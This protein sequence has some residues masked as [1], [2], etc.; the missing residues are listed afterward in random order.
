MKSDYLEKLYNFLSE[1]HLNIR[2]EVLIAELKE[3]SE[4][5]DDA[6]LIAN[7]STF[8]RTSAGDVL[9]VKLN[10]SA[11]K[12]MMELSRNGLYDNLPEGLFHTQTISKDTQSYIE[13]RKVIKSEEQSSRL[14]FSPIENE[15]F[16]QRLEI[17]QNERKLLNSFSK[18]QNEFLFD[19]WKID[20]EIPGDYAVKLMALLP[21][22]DRIVGDLA[23]TSLCLEKILNQKV[24]MDRTTKRM[25]NE[26]GRDEV[27]ISLGHDTVLEPFNYSVEM[28]ALNIMI[29][30]IP[31]ENIDWYLNEMKLHEFLEVFY[32]YFVPMEMEAITELLVDEASEFMLGDTN[33]GVIG[34][35]TLL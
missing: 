28:P 25:I 23:L 17:E 22:R 10:E 14:L 7:K 1:F 27:G 16:Y 32:D 8:S 18:L 19:F 13:R 26:E 33:K 21:Y 35:S 24:R 20:K 6:F 2:A 11:D 3:S 5:G 30:P 34:L 15:F 4:L 31:T 12:L 9:D 29:G